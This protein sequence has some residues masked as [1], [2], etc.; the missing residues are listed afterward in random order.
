MGIVQEIVI[1]NV[2]HLMKLYDMMV[3]LDNPTFRSHGY[4]DKQVHYG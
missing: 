3:S 4:D 1:N 2:D